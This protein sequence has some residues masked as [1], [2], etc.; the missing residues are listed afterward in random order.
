MS[1]L[2]SSRSK[3]SF[4]TYTEDAIRVKITT[5]ARPFRKLSKVTELPRLRMGIKT[6]DCLAH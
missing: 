6:I 2:S 5:A 3:R 1:A 4:K